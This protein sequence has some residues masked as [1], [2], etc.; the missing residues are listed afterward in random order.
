MWVLAEYQQVS[1]F[2]LKSSAATGS[3]AKSLLVPS[4]FAIKMALLDAACRTLGLVEARSVWPTIRDARCALDP[5][6]RATVTNLF[7]KVLKPRRGPDHEGS[8]DAGPFQRTIAFREYVHYAGSLGVGF[9]VPDDQGH[10]VL[11]LLLQVNYFGKR[12][13]FVQL[14]QA[15]QVVASLPDTYIQVDQQQTQFELAGILQMLDDCTS[16]LSFDQVNTF[17]AERVRLGRERIVH[18]IVLPYRLARSSKS[19]TLYERI[20]GVIRD[21]D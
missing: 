15:P 8:A 11:A 18:H 21:T 2:S 13:S 10:I 3:G 7:A 5:P 14:V 1:L 6:Q 20:G 9:H 16:S 12:G 19:Y 17:S 4:P